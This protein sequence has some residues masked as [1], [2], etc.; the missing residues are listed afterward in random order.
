[1]CSRSECAGTEPRCSMTCAP[2]EKWCGLVLV[3]SAVM[4]GAFDC[5]LPIN[6]PRC[7]LRLNAPNTLKG[8]CTTRYAPRS[9]NSVQVSGGNCVLQCAVQPTLSY[10]LHCGISS[11]LVKSP[12]IRSPRCVRCCKVHARARAHG[13]YRQRRR[14]VALQH[15]S[16]DHAIHD[17][18]APCVLARRQHKVGGVS[19]V[20]SS[21]L[22]FPARNRFT[23]WHC[24]CSSA[25]VCSRARRCLPR[26]FVAAL[27]VSMVC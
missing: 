20:N 11:G 14:R 12:T 5:S 19:F 15:D 7:C 9:P 10:S 21:M 24:R 27:R 22:R 23:R 4:T 16:C 8:S 1:M 6:S 13:L 18:R 2:A 25:M 3:R 17:R 26:V